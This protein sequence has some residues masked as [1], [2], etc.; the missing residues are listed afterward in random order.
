MKKEEAIKLI[1]CQKQLNNNQLP[2]QL[3]D[4]AYRLVPDTIPDTFQRVKVQA[5]QR[6]V[7]FNMD[8]IND[9]LKQEEM[10]TTVV[11]EQS[12]KGQKKTKTTTRPAKPRSKTMPKHGI[13]TTKK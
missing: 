6:Y 10:K 5:I 8:I 3:I 1:E 7:M 2:R 4:E 11:V 12:P 9:A 13:K